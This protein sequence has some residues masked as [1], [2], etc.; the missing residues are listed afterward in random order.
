V[1]GLCLVIVFSH[2]VD[3]HVAVLAVAFLEV[4][5]LLKAV[6][7]PSHLV[8]DPIGNVVGLDVQKGTGIA[9]FV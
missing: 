9:E 3:L 8:F 2:L 1:F 6:S 5:S 7:G 4:V